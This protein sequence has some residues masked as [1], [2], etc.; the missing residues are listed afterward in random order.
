MANGMTTQL[1]SSR[2]YG[3]HIVYD[4]R[5]AVGLDHLMGEPLWTSLGGNVPV[6]DDVRRY[7]ERVG[8][9]FRCVHIRADSLSKVPWVIANEAGDIVWKKG[10]QAPAQLLWLRSLPRLLQKSEA[11]LTLGAQAYWHKERNRVRVTGLRWLAPIATEPYWDVYGG[12]THF[13]RNNGIGIEHIPVSD[14]VYLRYEHPLHE[15]LRDV[16]PGEASMSS[17]GVL[18]NVDMFAATFF[19]RGAIK[20]TLLT[21]KGNPG[22]DEKERLKAW[23]NRVFT[24]V[25]NA[26][27]TEVVSADQV[28][29]VVIGEGINELA[30]TELTSEKREDVSATLGVPFSM[31]FSDASNYATAQQDEKNFYNSTII[32]ECELLAEQIDEQ[33]LAE[34]GLHLVFK[35]E[36]MDVFQE[37]E[38]E[39]AQ[40][41]A[42][43]VNAGVP[44][45][46]VGEMLGMDLPDGWSYE[47]LGIEPRANASG[48]ER[49]LGVSGGTVA[50]NQPPKA[51]PTGDEDP[52]KQAEARR[53]KAWAKR[54][55]G[56]A[57][58][59]PLA[60]ESEILSTGEKVILA[61][62]LVHDRKGTEGGTDQDF[63]T[64]TAITLPAGPITPSAYKAMLLQLDPDDDEAEQKVRL[65]IER[66]T[67]RELLRAFREQLG[68][69]LPPGASDD[70]IRSAASRVEATS[71]PVR[72]V[73]R[74]EL[75]QASSLGVTVA[76]DTLEG[77]GFGFDWTLANVE[78]SRW[79]SR[80]S[81]ELIRGINSTTAQRVQVAVDDWFQER[82]TL[83]DLVKELTP[84]FGRKRAKLIAQTETTRAATEG[85]LLGWAEAGFGEGRPTQTSPAHPGCRCWITLRI[86][87]DGSAE[88]VW[89]TARDER[90]CP[91]CGALHG[92]S[93]GYAK[94][95]GA[96]PPTPPP[97]PAGPQPQGPPVSNALKL[98]SSGKYKAIYEEAIGA[99]DR[100]HGD[101]TLPNLPVVTKSDMDAYGQ[102]RYFT[103]GK[104][105]SIRIN[106]KGNHHQLTLA[107]EIGHF[108]DQQALGGAKAM[109]SDR[110]P[111]LEAWRR[112]VDESQ[113]VQRLT[114][115]R[116]NP[117]NYA[118]EVEHA[119][120][121]YTAKPDRLFTAYLLRREEL[122]ARSYAQYIAERSGN[123]TLLA[124]LAAERVDSIYGDRHWDEADFAPIAAAIDT[125]FRGLGWLQ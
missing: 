74:R 80:Y 18:Y 8:L 111:R 108:L 106:S 79:A 120:Q 95:P 10:D 43:Y 14:M 6:N 26:F 114:D 11:A 97:P 119:G 40:S 39:K 76:L 61:A 30:N 93:Q 113:A 121:R 7:Y 49:L 55:I 58:F 21:V 70:Q 109:A 22:K 92:K 63:F 60:F 96:T 87:D 72:E 104:A 122:W 25:K 77:I 48:L 98:P 105:D 88:F 85:S 45:A 86:N 83:P 125:L 28:T 36:A 4:G 19:D 89:Q 59:D 34:Q 16:S 46:L 32:P 118:A 100:V 15:T 54:R 20:A 90:V 94:R 33:L 47:D 116:R 53:F 52:A 29:P 64:V 5:K 103:S 112:A 37:D 117:E 56:K 102:Y 17:S 3:G 75:E 123:A 67:E 84:T 23:W 62:Q 82:T 27:K 50:G 24:G 101:G 68:D 31:L 35:P 81:F 71:Q 99:I 107:H 42:A 73:L 51:S 44:P 65:E 78:A 2:P 124:Q 110:D 57:N 69:L 38:H 1:I 41:Y 12:L 91:I 9:L 13:V 115:K 66:R